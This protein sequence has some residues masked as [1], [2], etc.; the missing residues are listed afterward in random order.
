MQTI[1]ELKYCWYLDFFIIFG[2]LKVNIYVLFLFRKKKWQGFQGFIQALTD[3][4]LP[5]VK[6]QS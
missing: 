1:K 2:L 6:T 4:H 3:F 5:E